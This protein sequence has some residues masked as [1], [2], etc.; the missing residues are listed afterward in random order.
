MA[1]YCVERRHSGLGLCIPSP[2]LSLTDQIV[3]SCTKMPIHLHAYM[4]IALCI[5]L[6]DYKSILILQFKYRTVSDPGIYKGRGIFV[7]SEITVEEIVDKR[8]P[9]RGKRW[10]E[11]SR[12]CYVVDLEARF[13][14]VD[15]IDDCLHLV[16][17]FGDVLILRCPHS[18]ECAHVCKH[19]AESHRLV[20]RD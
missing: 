1:T 16:N 13:H 18:A 14:S 15:L 6:R 12:V 4:K 3:I 17:V 8:I 11:D 2:H 9:S 19:S 7:F 5:A 20:Q 10:C